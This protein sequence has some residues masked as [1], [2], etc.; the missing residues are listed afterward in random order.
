MVRIYYMSRTGCVEICKLEWLLNICRGQNAG[1]F[2]T[3][4]CNTQAAV[5]ESTSVELEGKGQ[6]VATN[7]VSPVDNKVLHI[8]FRVQLY[9]GRL[10]PRSP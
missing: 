10:A 7:T 9:R 8:M 4:A 1:S 2:S 6:P 3:L 5:P